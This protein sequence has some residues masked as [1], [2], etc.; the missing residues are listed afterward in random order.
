LEY[1]AGAISSGSYWARW[2][3]LL[4]QVGPATGPGGPCYW[5]RWALLLGQAGP[6]VEAHP[7]FG[8][9]GPWLSLLHPVLGLH[10]PIKTLNITIKY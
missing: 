9:C 7:F 3:L 4:G 5:A 1:F 8:S 2:A 10:C 6:T